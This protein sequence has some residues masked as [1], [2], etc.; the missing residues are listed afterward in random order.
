MLLANDWEKIAR[1]DDLDQNIIDDID[2]VVGQTRLL[3]RDK[4]KQF[5][6]LIEQHEADH[7]KIKVTL[8]DL[9]G[10]WDMMYLQV[11]VND[12]D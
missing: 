3:T 1:L 7:D 5:R 4:F 2:L 10:F 9:I 6:T 12:I 8:D 11:S